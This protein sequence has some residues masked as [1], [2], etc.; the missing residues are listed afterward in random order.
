MGN[1]MT[2][3]SCILILFPVHDHSFADRI[4]AAGL[5]LGY[6]HADTVGALSG[7]FSTHWRAGA[8]QDPRGRQITSA[9]FM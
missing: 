6:D 7:P 5:V 4:A 3:E 1:L 9:G 2:F 8:V